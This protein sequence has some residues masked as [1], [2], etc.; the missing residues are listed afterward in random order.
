MGESLWQKV[1]EDN[2][3]NWW[4]PPPVPSVQ[5]TSEP[6]PQLP[7]LFLWMPKKMWLVDLSALDVKVVKK[8]RGANEGTAHWCTNIG[9]E[10]G[11][12]VQCVLTVSE[13]AD[14]LGLMD[15]SLT[16][17]YEKAMVDY[18]KV[19]YKNRNCYCSGEGPSK[20]HS[21]FHKWQSLKV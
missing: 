7:C 17:R 8:L 18:P 19:L 21:L 1:N 13:G 5:V 14:S 3:V 9:K 15:T 4:Y 10:Q 2:L 11:K 12:I 6:K 16:D 20:Y